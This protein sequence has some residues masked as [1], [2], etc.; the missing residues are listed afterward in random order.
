MRIGTL[1]LA[2]IAAVTLVGCG[3]PGTI[4]PIY[5]YPFAKTVQCSTQDCSLN[6]T[7]TENA[8][9]GTCVIEVAD[10][11]DM[12]GGPAGQRNVTWTITTP[13][14]EFSKEFYKYGIFI[15]SNPDD[16]FK[17]VQITG[18]GTSLSIQ[19]KHQ[20]TGIDYSY[21]LSVRRTNKTFCETLDPW[22]IS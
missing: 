12:K 1:L 3:S 2:A 18:P 16:E 22:M 4:K 15:K 9:T 5:F 14:Y 21:A 10:I 8:T 20:Q 19:F 11:L 7:V 17:N 13:G 6:V